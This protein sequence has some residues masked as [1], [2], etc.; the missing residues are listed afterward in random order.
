MSTIGQ[1]LTAARDRAGYTIAE[2][3]ARTCIR[4]I[5]LNGMEHDDFGPCGGDFYARGHIKAVCR[6]LGVDPTELVARYDAEHSSSASSPLGEGAGRPARPVRGGAR[7]NADPPDGAGGAGDAGSAGGAQGGGDGRPQRRGLFA[8]LRSA[9]AEAVGAFTAETA[10]AGQDRR[11][12]PGERRPAADRPGHPAEGYREE[13]AEPEAPYPVEGYREPYPEVE[14]YPEAEAYPRVEPY[15]EEHLPE[16][17]R[18]EPDRWAQGYPQEA[19][20]GRRPAPVPAPPPAPPEGAPEPAARPEEAAAFAEPQEP[21]GGAGAEWAAHPEAAAP[22]AVPE[23]AEEYRPVPADEPAEPVRAAEEYRPEPPADRPAPLPDTQPW[24]PFP[25]PVPENGLR[26]SAADAAEEY[27]EA[28]LRGAPQLPG[29]DAGRE[30]GDEGRDRPPINL[31]T[32]GLGAFR[33]RRSN[34]GILGA[35]AACPEPEHREAP[36][37]ERAAPEQPAAPERAADE[38]AAAGPVGAGPEH[39][40]SD[41][42]VPAAGF[43]RRGAASD[44]H[45]LPPAAQPAPDEFGRPVAGGAAEYR[46][47]HRYA[48]EEQRRPASDPAATAGHRPA[49][50]LAGGAEPFGAAPEGNRGGRPVRAGSTGRPVD[51][52]LALHEVLGLPAPESGGESAARGFRRSGS[53][54]RPPV[55]AEPPAAQV[56][57]PRDARSAEAGRTG[58]APA[59]LR[60]GSPWSALGLAGDGTV[61]TAATGDWEYATPY[62]PGQGR[63]EEGAAPVDGRGELGASTERPGWLRRNWPL[64]VAACLVA[65]A[66]IA[67]IRA[68]PEGGIQEV[69]E[70]GIEQEAGGQTGAVAGEGGADGSDGSDRSGG[71]AEEKSAAEG[72][73]TAAKEHPVTRA[74]E[75]QQVTDTTQALQRAEEVRVKLHA[76][77]RTWVEVTDASGAVVYTGTVPQGTSREWTNADELN[78]HL[79]DPSSVRV[80]VNGE[81]RQTGRMTRLTFR[82]D[83]LDP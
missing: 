9:M 21:A 67:G 26:E 46:E 4:D 25:G 61:L 73:G 33:S 31:E 44:E 5:V 64:G 18:P 35:G 17:A 75:P 34:G 81:E 8:P 48:P 51:P 39:R 2:L 24:D 23:P 71:G 45:G 43:G 47:P 60:A 80:A 28:S 15:P 82:A 3:S 53:S 52:G 68:W 63:H 83:E 56:P 77:E 54:A 13:G 74:Q 79:G 62:P 22:Q 38:Q 42:A 40:P 58:A 65:A 12:A 37:G 11:S 78:L 41:G 57:A 36:I 69:R 30:D 10:D 66:V 49:E 32:A 19:G 29:P 76:T 72:A 1:I 20:H 16:Q 7:A 6:E 27:G 14:P 59:A 70:A 50:A 55:P